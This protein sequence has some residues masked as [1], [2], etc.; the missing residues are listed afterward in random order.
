MIFPWMYAAIFIC[1]ILGLPFIPENPTITLIL[2]IINTSIFG[3]VSYFI[4]SR[5]LSAWR[6]LRLIC[7]SF[8]SG[9]GNITFL[10]IF[11][12]LFFYYVQAVL[13]TIQ[14]IRQSREFTQNWWIKTVSERAKSNGWNI[15]RK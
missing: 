7:G 5:H 2:A 4:H 13:K 9:C 6:G 3:C 8:M 10:Y 1:L 14:G 11:F 12:V 15:L